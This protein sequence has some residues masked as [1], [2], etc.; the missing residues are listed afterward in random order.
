MANPYIVQHFEVRHGGPELN[1][2]DSQINELFLAYKDQYVRQQA[3]GSM[4]D[5]E[6]LTYLKKALREPETIVLFN[7]DDE[8]A[9]M[10]GINYFDENKD[11]PNDSLVEFKTL[12]VCHKYRGQGI[13]DKLRKMLRD[14]TVARCPKERGIIFTSV[15]STPQVIHLLQK[16]G[17]EEI[18]GIDWAQ[19]TGC[20]VPEAYRQKYGYRAFIDKKHGYPTELN[21][22]REGFEDKFNETAQVDG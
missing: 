6:I 13:S 19:M 15:T 17:Y 10:I 14:E 8:V 20:T 3:D 11:F 22:L 1:I 9:G 21:S 2:S 12:I 18:P 4:P 7:D 5:E 16:D